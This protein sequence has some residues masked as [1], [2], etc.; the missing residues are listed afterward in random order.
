MAIEE[1]KFIRKAELDK[2][3]DYL[4]ANDPPRRHPRYFLAV[5]LASE[6]G[7]RITETVHLRIEDFR[8]I[9]KAVLIV[10]VAKKGIT[11]K[12]KITPD[13]RPEHRQPVSK[14]VIRT[15]LKYFE[16]AGIDYKTEEGWLLPGMRGPKARR[17]AS[18]RTMHSVFT[19]ACQAA[20]IGHRTFHCLRHYFGFRIARETNGDVTLVKELLRHADL[21]TAQMY[22]NRTPDELRSLLDRMK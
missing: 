18:E 19:A 16:W 4:K 2:V 15:C 1:K 3:L 10:R 9:E 6:C 20:G 14:R 5:Y 12:C 13:Q 21:Q 22:I 11:R 7:L 8:E 17:P